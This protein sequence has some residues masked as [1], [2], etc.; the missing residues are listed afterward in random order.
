MLNWPKKR[1]LNK[2]VKCKPGNFRQGFQWLDYILM[3]VIQLKQ[4]F[5]HFRVSPSKSMFL[6][7]IACLNA[8]H[9]AIFR[10][11]CFW[12]PQVCPVDLFLQIRLKRHLWSIYPDEYVS[13]SDWKIHSAGNR[14]SSSLASS[15]LVFWIKRE[16]W[17]EGKKL[18]VRWN[19]TLKHGIIIYFTPFPQ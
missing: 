10:L 5:N 7:G 9:K 3:P 12:S 4:E 6:I 15:P 16:S 17:G 19:F 14:P 1:L 2:M 11:T 18:W 8:Y 13:P